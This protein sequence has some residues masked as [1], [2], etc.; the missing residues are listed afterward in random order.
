MVLEGNFYIS[1]LST[2]RNRAF[3]LGLFVETHNYSVN[4]ESEMDVFVGAL[5][6][7]ALF[8]GHPYLSALS[9]LMLKHLD[10]ISLS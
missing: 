6:V 10:H 5:F 2:M 3:V 4:Y 8:V 7:G 1:E 9:S